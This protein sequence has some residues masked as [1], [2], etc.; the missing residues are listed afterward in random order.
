M[1][2]NRVIFNLVALT[3]T[4]CLLSTVLGCDAFVRKFTRKSKRNN[5]P[6]EEMVLAPEEY[7]GPQM[8]KEQF[9]RQNFMFW[10]SWHDEL[11]TYLRPGANHK[12]QLACAEQ[13][14]KS[15]INL[16]ALLNQ[17]QQKKLE[18]YLN[19]LIDIRDAIIKDEY[20]NNAANNG[21]KVERIK[22]EIM[23]NFD[24]SAVVKELA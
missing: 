12:K 10:E 4:Y 2:K 17:E 3:T 15:L 11:I 21:V 13:T 8:T 19:Q 7:K 20:G 14:I 1:K 23:R 24:Y 9:Y 6:K 18:V 16:K 22:R 5:I